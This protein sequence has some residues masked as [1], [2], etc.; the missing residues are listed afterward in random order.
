MGLAAK[1]L[2]SN[3]WMIFDDFLSQEIWIALVLISFWPGSW[4]FAVAFDNSKCGTTVL[5]G[6]VVFINVWM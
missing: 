6:L 4:N 5:A 1:A 2:I 3:L